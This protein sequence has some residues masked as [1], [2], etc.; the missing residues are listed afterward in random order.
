[1]DHWAKSKYYIQ[2]SQLEQIDSERLKIQEG[3][4]YTSQM[5]IKEA[6]VAILIIRQFRNSKW[7]ALIDCQGHEK[8]GT[9]H[10]L[11]EIWWL[12]AMWDFGLDLG[13]EKGHEWTNWWNLNK[14]RSLVNSS[15]QMPIS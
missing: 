4:K 5:Q 15:I 2:E 3:Q 14:V 8:T 9:V 7:K 1:M 10:S 12:N 13:T 11:E 6:E